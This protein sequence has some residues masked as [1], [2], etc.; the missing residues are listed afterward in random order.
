MVQRKKFRKTNSTIHRLSCLNRSILRQIESRDDEWGYSY[1]LLLL[2]L[3]WRHS[4][5]LA[6]LTLEPVATPKR[7]THPEPFSFEP[8]FNPVR[9]TQQSCL[10]NFDL[11]AASGCFH[12]DAMNPGE[13][14]RLVNKYC[15]H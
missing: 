10:S 5:S 3:D 8:K 14:I 6:V 2:G 12:Y 7:D 13:S 11:V 15:R 1:I 4:G 9:Q